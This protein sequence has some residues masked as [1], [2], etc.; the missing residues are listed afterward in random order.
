MTREDRLTDI[1]DYVHYLEALS[2][3]VLTRLGEEAPSG[4]GER[5]RRVA[6]G[7]SQGT[8]TVARWAARTRVRLDELIL[9]GGKLPPELEP[10]DLATPWR[11]VQVTLV[12]GTRDRWLRREAL[13]DEAA[14]LGAHG[15]R[16]RVVT[17]EGGH[18]LDDGAL[19]RL[20][21][22][23]ETAAAAA[24]GTREPPPTS[25]DPAPGR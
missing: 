25:G 12:A 16:A 9:W 17:F 5:V 24:P 2:S 19:L 13:D 10:A 20:A 3:A 1:E 23:H 18:R 15:I 22:E 11:A 7:F 8:A 21:E 4:R 14:K 6:L